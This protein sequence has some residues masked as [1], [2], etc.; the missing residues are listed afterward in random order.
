MV[1]H[2][3]T[4]LTVRD[5]AHRLG[6]SEPTIRRAIQRGELEAVKSQ[7]LVRIPEHSWKLYLLEYWPHRNPE[8][9]DHS[10]RRS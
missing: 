9:Q 2:E 8:H 5:C 7:R 6:V 4:W 10:S 3:E 1:V